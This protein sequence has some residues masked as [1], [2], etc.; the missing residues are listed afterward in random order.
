[1]EFTILK[2]IDQMHCMYFCRALVG[3]KVSPRTLALLKSAYGG[4]LFP[5]YYRMYFHQC[6]Y[7]WRSTLLNPKRRGRKIWDYNAS[8][9]DS[10]R[11]TVDASLLSYDSYGLRI[12]KMTSFE[13]SLKATLL[14]LTRSK[15]RIS[16][17]MRTMPVQ[18]WP[19][20]TSQPEEDRYNRAHWTFH[21]SEKSCVEWAKVKKADEKLLWTMKSWLATVADANF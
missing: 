7:L 6:S 1:M 17:K 21:R 3:G 18:N 11:I 9:A 16:T 2:A 20:C 13:I 5:A 12:S 14:I 19:I 15:V 10:L 4:W 8:A